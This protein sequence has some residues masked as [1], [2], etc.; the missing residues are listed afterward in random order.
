M[1]GYHAHAYYASYHK[2]I[3]IL[4]A[5]LCGTSTSHSAH[6]STRMRVQA[7]Y[8]LVRNGLGFVLGL[9]PA[10]QAYAATF[11]AIPFAR[12]LLNGAKNAEIS[13]RNDA[14]IEAVELLQ[15]GDAEL[16]AKEA[17]ARK[18]GERRVIGSNQII[19]ERQ[20]GS[21]GVLKRGGG[22]HP[23]RS[24]D[25]HA[26]HAHL[27]QAHT[28]THRSSSLQTSPPATPATPHRHHGN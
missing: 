20:E 15:S 27:A 18:L 12:S 19:C 1:S 16:A 23:S 28:H 10:L 13:G 21:G 17:A 5:C 4:V 3:L 7:K 22:R 26:A 9:L 25:W 8:A 11:F 6:L 24:L 2:T 14:R